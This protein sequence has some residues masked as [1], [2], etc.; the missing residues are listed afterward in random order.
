MNDLFALAEQ[1]RTHYLKALLGS[2]AE[3][4]AGHSPSAPEAMFELP[5]ECALPYRLYR[6]DMAAN[7]DGEA[8]LQDVNTSSHL[9]FEPFDLDL[10]GG[11]SAT[12]QPFAWN[13]VGITANIR[14]PDDPVESWAMRWLDLEDEHTDDE[15]GLQAVIH[16]ISRDDV[17]TDGTRLA[18]DFGSAPV[19]ALEELLDILRASGASRVT[20]HSASGLTP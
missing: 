20:V 6:A 2:L 8:K 18:V 14:L 11:L 1:V 19:E 13:D 17:G 5:R 12:V 16:S 9:S 3:F 15:N 7:V 10:G 4:K